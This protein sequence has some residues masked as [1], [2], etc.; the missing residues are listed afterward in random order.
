MKKI[1]LIFLFLSWPHFEETNWATTR[2]EAFWKSTFKQMTFREPI[3]F[4]PYDIR[5]GYYEYGG[6]NYFNELDNFLSDNDN[7]ESSPYSSSDLNFPNIV[8]KKFRKM[9]ALEIDFLRYNFFK[10]RQNVIDIQFGFGYRL[11]KNINK[12]A[13]NNGDYLKPEFNEFN[14]NGTFIMQFNPRYYNYLYYSSG[15]TRASFYDNNFTNSE[16]KGSGISNHLGLGINFIIPGN[17]EKSNFHCGLELRLS[18]LNIDN[19]DEPNN[20]S[21]IDD[22]NMESIG[23]LFSFGVGYGGKKTLGDVAYSSM[24]K[25]NYIDAYEKLKLYKKSSRTY[26]MSEVNEMIQFSKNKIPYQLYNNAMAYYDDGEFKKALKLLKKISYKDDIDLDYKINSIKYIIADKMLNNFIKIENEQSID[27]RIQYY[28]DIKDISPKIRKAVNKR[29]SILY[30][31]K[32][33]YLLS[34]N[35]YE[36]AYEFYMYSKTTGEHNPEQIKI[37]LSNLIIVALNDAYGFLEKKENVIAYEKLFFVKNIADNN[38][39]YILSLMNF[40]DNRIQTIK[41]EKIKERMKAILKD[42]ETFIPTQIKKEILI[43]DSYI[44]VIDIMGEPLDEISRSKVNSIYKMIKYA[45]D[46]NIYRLFFK[47]DILIDIDFE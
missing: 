24:L 14:I 29:L 8:N 45:I 5:I 20:L 1:F 11:Y 4:L 42:K 15:Y 6:S 30:L 2:F 47:D 33:D 12:V 35:N 9:I 44:K 26:N 16:S 23:L 38:N 10:D 46:N 17:Q 25:N 27:Y 28:S 21:R 18:S 43:G 39:E 34:N 31:Q 13:F 22:F 19:I 40:L 7:L 37:K 36:E 3:D 32:G 41:S